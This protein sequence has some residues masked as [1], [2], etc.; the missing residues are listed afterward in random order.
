[1]I[2]GLDISTSITGYSIVD[3]DGK[4]IEIGHW[5]TRN[6]NKFKDFYEKVAFV[7]SNLKKIDYPID[8][9]FI[10]PALNMFMMGRSSSHTISTLTKFNGIVSW[11]CYEEFGLKPEY[12]P[13]ISARKKCGI[14]VKKGEKAKEKVLSFLLDSEPIFRVEYTRNGKPK[15][16]CYDEADSLVIAKAG[17]VC[18]REKER[19]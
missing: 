13:A 15:P 5:D 17:A 18:L 12:I 4:I 14:T 19:S 8:Y 9:I 3:L 1:L 16:H 11:L 2:L 10:E 6:K 7:K